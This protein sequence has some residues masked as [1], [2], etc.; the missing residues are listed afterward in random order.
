MDDVQPSDTGYS[1]LLIP[2]K[3]NPIGRFIGRPGNQLCTLLRAL[4]I[5]DGQHATMGCRIV[6]GSLM[7][8]IVPA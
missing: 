2:S 7:D 1:I 5:S 4:D 3:R 8:L 6:L